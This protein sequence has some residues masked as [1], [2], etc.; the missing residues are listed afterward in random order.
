MSSERPARRFALIDAK[1]QLYSF[2][3][4]G[5][6]L[7]QYHSDVPLSAEMIEEMRATHPIPPKEAA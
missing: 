1:S 7:A 6:L 3:L 2:Y 4:E 5:R